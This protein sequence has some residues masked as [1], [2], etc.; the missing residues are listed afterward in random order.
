MSCQSKGNPLTTP[1]RLDY[2]LPIV[3]DWQ[4]TQTNKA[5]TRLDPEAVG[6]GRGHRAKH[7]GMRRAR[8]SWHFRTRGDVDSTGGGGK[9]S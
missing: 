3:H 5:A 6:R 7:F 2:R 1:P 8:G 4:T 9:A